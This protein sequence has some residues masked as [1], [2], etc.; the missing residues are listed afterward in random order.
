M[1]G[2]AA[3]GVPYR[4]PPQ[5]R[6]PRRQKLHH[7]IKAQAANANG[8]MGGAHPY[9]TADTPM[10]MPLVAVTTS[11]SAGGAEITSAVQDLVP[12]VTAD[13]AV[14]PA[15][16]PGRWDQLRAAGRI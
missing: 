9:G 2:I 5:P 4:N 6:G 8:A 11:A 1:T 16:G 12:L 15:T 14:V 7:R 3:D 10:L 13:G